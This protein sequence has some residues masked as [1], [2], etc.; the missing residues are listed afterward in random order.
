MFD[1]IGAGVPLTSPRL[2]SGGTTDDIRVALM[3][4]SATYPKAP[5]LGIGFSLGA[6]VLTRY[7]A[8]EGEHSR[9]KAGCVLASVSKYF[10]DDSRVANRVPVVT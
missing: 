5:L 4:I 9:L 2:Y 1:F 8:E 7:L 3:Y 10:F 6:N